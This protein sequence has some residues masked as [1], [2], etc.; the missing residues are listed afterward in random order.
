METAKESSDI[1]EAIPKR[2]EPAEV[3]KPPKEGIKSW[4]ASI[5]TSIAAAINLSKQATSL[6]ETRV[7]HGI[8]DKTSTLFNRAD[9]IV[10][11]ERTRLMSLGLAP[12]ARPGSYSQTASRGDTSEGK[13]YT[14]YPHDS[15]ISGGEDF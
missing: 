14:T 15:G 7:T 8:L 4:V 12:P 1:P 3:S 6:E 10:E 9:A 13:G 2:V 11:L 5:R